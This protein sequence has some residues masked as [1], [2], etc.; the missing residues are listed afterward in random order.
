M[1]AAYKPLRYSLP[2]SLSKEA[3]GTEARGNTPTE[4]IPPKLA[5]ERP[6]LR[7][8]SSTHTSIR[9]PKM[10]DIELAPMSK[11]NDTHSDD[12]EDEEFARPGGAGVLRDYYDD[13]NDPRAFFH[14]A[15]KDPQ[16]IIWIP[17]DVSGLSS[18]EIQ[19]MHE[20][21]VAATSK[22][23]SMATDVSVT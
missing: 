17:S 3:Y 10:E 14:P 16:R 9:A 2:L 8:R 6:T 11:S 20:Q 5:G 7:H 23:A 19:A 1:N 4:D 13:G 21:G 15:T 22:H 18:T 12:I